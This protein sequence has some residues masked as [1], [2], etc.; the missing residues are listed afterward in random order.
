MQ[1][2]YHFYL[3]G[4]KSSL[5]EGGYNSII[6]GMLKCINTV[7]FG[8]TIALWGEILGSFQE[9]MKYVGTIRAQLHHDSYVD[10]ML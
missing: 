4:C 5:K 8:S 9:E 6:P 3:M 2:S 7:A 1:V 10:R